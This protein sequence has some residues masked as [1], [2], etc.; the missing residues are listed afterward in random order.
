MYPWF[1]RLGV[2]TLVAC[3]SSTPLGAQVRWSIDPQPVL[4]LGG[5]DADGV[6]LV[7]MPSGATRRPDGSFV[8]ADGT[9]PALR[10]FDSR[11]RLTTSVG[12]AGSGPGEYRVISWLGR[13]AGDSLVVYDLFQRRFSVLDATGRFSRQFA[14][15]GDAAAIACAPDGAL[16]VLGG[17]GNTPHADRRVRGRVSMIAPTG[18]VRHTVTDVP[19]YEMATVGGMPLPHPLGP[20][21]AVAL[22]RDRLYVGTGADAAVDAYDRT[23]R[24]LATHHLPGEDRRPTAAHHEAGVTEFVRFTTD[25]GMRRAMEAQLAKL[26][27]RE[28]LPPYSAL[29]SDR[30]GYLWVHRSV[31]G[32]ATSRFTVLTPDGRLAAVVQMPT[33]V[34]VFEVRDDYALGA[35]E[36]EDGESRVVL[37]RLRRS[38]R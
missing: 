9:A 8:V 5:K 25:A 12:R 19:F 22:T 2:V 20:V 16:A 27:P 18:E 14:A 33:F 1:S 23:A 32:D 21:T 37:W 13:C 38:A 31:P 30:A 35:Q 15:P 10:F 17:A 6:P 29:L 11:G 3:L 28:S 7:A 4:T 34:R 36:D 26:S 24:K